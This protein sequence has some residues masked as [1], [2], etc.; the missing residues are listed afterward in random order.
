MDSYRGA[1]LEKA[2]KDNFTAL[3]IAASNG[4]VNSLKVLIKLHADITVTD[5]Y[6]RT[7]LH[8]AA[9]EDQP[10]IIKVTS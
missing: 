7:A 3:L 5:K 10:A 9:Q 8:W 1:R 6:E 4:H 2:D